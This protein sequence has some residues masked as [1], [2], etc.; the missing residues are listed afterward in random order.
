MIQ[1]KRECS[2]MNRSG[3]IQTYGGFCMQATMF[4]FYVNCLHVD[5]MDGSESDIENR[6]TGSLFQS[7]MK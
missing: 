3:E 6:L 1:N 7:L 5:L 2:I 4:G